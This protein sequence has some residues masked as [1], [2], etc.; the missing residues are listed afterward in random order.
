MHGQTDK[1]TE[2]EIQKHSQLQMD[3]QRA[4]S[5]REKNGQDKVILDF[6]EAEQSIGSGDVGEDRS[7]L[8]FWLM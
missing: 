7:P 4:G 5:G 2:E 3:V 8:G 6:K 1:K